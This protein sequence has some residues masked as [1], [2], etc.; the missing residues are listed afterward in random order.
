M[1]PHRPLSIAIFLSTAACSEHTMIGVVKDDPAD[2][3]TGLLDEEE[4]AEE[5]DCSEDTTGFDIEEVSSLQDAFGL[6]SVQD[7]LTLDVNI[8]ST[9]NAESWRPTS[10]KALVMYPEWYFYQYDDSNALSVHFVPASSPLEGQKYSK[11]LQVTRS[12]L[13]WEPL[14]L[15]AN[16]DWSGD[17]RE[18]VAA[19]LEFDLRDVVPEEGFTSETY[20]VA[21]QWDSMGFPN[22]GYSNFELDCSRN[23]TDYGGGQFVQNSGQDCSWPMLKIELE[24]EIDGDC[25]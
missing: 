12:G 3:D 1:T 17:D 6:P 16:A 9:N 21:L 2:S 25:D 13:D 8:A 24:S 11:R 5:D 10:V 20:F 18:Q 22:V 23:W 14:T 19:W 15:P 7:G 4:P